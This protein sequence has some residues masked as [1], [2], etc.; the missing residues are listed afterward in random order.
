MKLKESLVVIGTFVTL[1]SGF[2][3]FSPQIE[4]DYSNI[5]YH[6]VKNAQD[7]L[8]LEDIVEGGFPEAIIFGHEKYLLDKENFES[9]IGYPGMIGLNNQPYELESIDLDGDNKPETLLR[10]GHK[11]YILD[12][13]KDGYLM[14]KYFI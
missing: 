13:N 4:K 1:A 8:I 6:Y 14:F 2:Y 9:M 3:Y 12:F 5:K 7:V 10:V 11:S